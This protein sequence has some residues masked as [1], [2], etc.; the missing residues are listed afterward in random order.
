ME[1]Y[2]SL[3]PINSV[4]GLAPST[5]I[6]ERAELVMLPLTSL[7]VDE[8][9]QRPITNKGR[10][11]VS[12]IVA[13]FDWRKFTPLVVTEVEGGL[14]A[15]IDGQ[16]RATAAL[17]H[18]SVHLVPCMVVKTTVAEAADTFAAINGART[19]VSTGQLFK[20]RLA[21]GDEMALAVKAACDVAGVV[22]L[23]HRSDSLGS[24]KPGETL[25]VATIERAFRLY[26]RDVLITTLQCVT[27][28]GDGNPGSL[29]A[30]LI[31]ALCDVLAARADW[32]D[33][34]SRLLDAFDLVSF[35]DMI[36]RGIRDASRNRTTQRGALKYLIEKHL[37]THL[38]AEG[39]VRPAKTRQRM[40][41]AAE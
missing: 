32:R 13:A 4:K 11:I 9:Y 19:D 23:A 16:H 7:V 3:T 17:M 21:S 22:L 35:E 29:R 8:R 33:A 2:R 41:E 38:R 24:Y 27:Q 30:P 6:G 12:R 15:I 40:L 20:S 39:A 18:P 36:E 34:G 14:Y 28:T 5:S 26:G 31:W 10:M 37:D 1:N 25:A